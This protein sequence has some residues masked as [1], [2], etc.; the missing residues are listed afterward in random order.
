[1]I[2][3]NKE[4]ERQ[5]STLICQVKQY[6]YAI[7]KF[8]KSTI[9]KSATVLEAAKTSRGLLHCVFMLNIFI[10]INI[11]VREALSKEKFLMYEDMSVTLFSIITIATIL[12]CFMRYSTTFK[13]F[14]YQARKQIYKGLQAVLFFTLWNLSLSIKEVSIQNLVIEC[15]GL[16]NFD[17]LLLPEIEKSYLFNLGFNKFMS[18]KE[19]DILVLLQS[20]P[21][22]PL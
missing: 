17:L 9:G 2:L 19:L 4:T 10:L 15:I 16:L 3:K 11:E 5:E 22:D 14:P 13:E 12:I 20:F 1:M 18:E 7:T 8:R 6:F 21:S